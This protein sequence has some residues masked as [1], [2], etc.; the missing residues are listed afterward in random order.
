[1][2]DFHWLEPLCTESSIAFENNGIAVVSNMGE[3]IG[4]PS[5]EILI[6]TQ[7]GLEAGGKLGTDQT[8]WIRL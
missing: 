4:L 6:S 2:G 3:P 5:G 1:L 8:A 7:E